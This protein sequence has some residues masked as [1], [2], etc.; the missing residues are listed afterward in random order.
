MKRGL[1][2]IAIMLTMIEA[3]WADPPVQQQYAIVYFGTNVYLF[4]DTNT[5]L[6][7]RV[8]AETPEQ[9]AYKETNWLTGYEIMWAGSTNPAGDGPNG[10]LMLWD[11]ANQMPWYLLEGET[12]ILESWN[13][14]TNILWTIGGAMAD[15]LPKW[16]GTINDDE[17]SRIAGLAAGSA[18]EWSEHP[19]Y[20]GVDLGSNYA[21]NV[22]HIFST[23]GGTAFIQLTDGYLQLH[24]T[25]GIF[26]DDYGTEFNLSP[27]TGLLTLS[28]GLVLTEPAGINMGNS[29]ITNWNAWSRFAPT[30]TV[31]WA[32]Q[33]ITNIS[34]IQGAS[35]LAIMD[36]DANSFTFTGS[37]LV[38]NIEN[39]FLLDR[40]TGI[41]T[42]G[43]GLYLGET[44]AID[45]Y[46]G[47]YIDGDSP[48]V[49]SVGPAFKSDG[50]A[51]LSGLVTCS[52]NINLSALTIGVTNS[53]H[54]VHAKT[55]NDFY[56]TTPDIAGGGCGDIIIKAGYGVSG[57]QSGHI[58]LEPGVAGAGT[59][60]RIIV[61]GDLDMNESPITNASIIV[62]SQ[63]PLTSAIYPD[64]TNLMFRA[65]NGVIGTIQMTY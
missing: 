54:G 59:P 34:R 37:L 23:N 19:A 30:Q 35:R 38:D 43:R 33:T 22:T 8:L 61:A 26:V 58:Y 40:D 4:D 1:W 11:W 63:D 10:G 60:G 56:I 62:F 45:F 6:H 39:E 3:A 46:G 48:S 15:E 57:G 42:L 2:I 5:P 64:G 65:T 18:E 24:S 52:S 41:L 53:R 31:N 51:R 17:A 36:I 55:T 9:L 44:A 13:N 49:V 32:Q 20:Q 29:L 27:D 47:A 16:Q 21:T 50:P 7:E 28:A 14:K 12:N 25:K